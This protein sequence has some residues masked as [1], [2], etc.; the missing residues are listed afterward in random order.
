MVTHDME[1]VAAYA[2]RVIVMVDGRIVLDGDPKEVFYDNFDT[3]T[4]MQLKP[5]TTIDFCRRLEAKG[6]Q[7]YMT[8]GTL[9]KWI[10]GTACPTSPSVLLNIDQHSDCHG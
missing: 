8:V 5:P 9:C 2:T 4:E 10:E 3:L 6:M 7:R 1:L